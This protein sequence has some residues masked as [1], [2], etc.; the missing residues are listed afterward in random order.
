MLY[1]Y[2]FKIHATAKLIYC[3]FQCSSAVD[4]YVYRF[5]CLHKVLR[6]HLRELLNDI[7]V[8]FAIKFSTIEEPQDVFPSWHHLYLMLSVG[9]RA[10]IAM[11]YLFKTFL[12]HQL[13][14]V[15]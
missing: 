11:N 5:H 15:K 6:P 4:S 2:P 3:F 7:L 1:W 12:T 14:K 8:F 13:G 9:L 10:S